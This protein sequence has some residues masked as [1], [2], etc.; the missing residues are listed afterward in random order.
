MFIPERLTK[1]Y[2]SWWIDEICSFMIVI[3]VITLTRFKVF[4]LI[5]MKCYQQHDIFYHDNKL[6]NN[7]T[8]YKNPLYTKYT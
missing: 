2:H 7:G 4:F 1:Y 6:N 5:L 8:Y 3:Y